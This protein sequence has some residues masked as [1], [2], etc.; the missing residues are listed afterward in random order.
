MTVF[1]LTVSLCHNSPLKAPLPVRLPM[2]GISAMCV[3]SG[4]DVVPSIVNTAPIQHQKTTIK[5]RFSALTLTHSHT[6]WLVHPHLFRIST[7][8]CNSTPPNQ[9]PLGYFWP[10]HL[11]NQIVKKTQRQT[12]IELRVSCTVPLAPAASV[13]LFSLCIPWCWAS[14]CL[15]TGR[16]QLGFIDLLIK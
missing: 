14:V 8:L 5:C 7:K 4:R 11:I 1:K 15:S 16:S 2:F 10:H 6:L 12:N 9:G 3:A 13:L